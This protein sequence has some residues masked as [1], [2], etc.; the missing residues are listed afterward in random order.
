MENKTIA[1]YDGP[2]GCSSIG[3]ALKLNDKGT[4]DILLSQGWVATWVL[5]HHVSDSRNIISVDYR[6]LVSLSKR[7]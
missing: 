6:F 1:L 3:T 5:P 4:A 2:H 7:K